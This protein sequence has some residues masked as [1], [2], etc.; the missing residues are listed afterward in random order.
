MARR[1]RT[2]DLDFIESA[3]LRLVFAAE[4]AA[5]P[6]AVYRALADD[7]EATPE[8]FTQVTAARPVDAGAGREVRLRG[9]IRFRE[10]IVAAEP[11]RRYA[12]RIDESNAP[13]LHALVEEW[14]LTPAGTGT[15]V[16]WT[17]AADGS[18]LFRFTLRRARPAVGRSF[19]DAVRNLGRRLSG[20]AGG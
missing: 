15:R 14:L 6:E 11:G 19:R 18:A 16:R 1:L 10:T 20:P 3:P 12:Y 7:V 2:V 9:G 13:G 17:F 4:V 5:P 8:W